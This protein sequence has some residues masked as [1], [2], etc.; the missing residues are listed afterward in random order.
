MS[1]RR[2]LPSVNRARLL[3][4]A[5]IG[6]AATAA[7]QERAS[8]PRIAPRS[9]QEALASFHPQHGFRLDLLAAEPLVTDPVALE[10]DENGR[11]YVAEMSDYP[12]TDKS[13]DRPF[14]E[15]STDRPLGRIRIL[16]DVDGDGRFDRSTIFAEQLSWPTGLAFWKGGVFVIATPDLWYLKDSDGDGRADVRRRV[17][18]GFR[19]FNIQAV[20]NNLRWG[21]DQRIYAAGSSNGGDLH[22]A[23]RPHDKTI[24]LG[25]ND[26]S[27]NP[28]DESIRIEAGGA[29]F[30]NSLDDWGN[31]FI[32]NIRNPIQ[33]VV[34]PNHYLARNPHLVVRSAVHDAANA[35]DTLPV[36][37]TSPPEPWRIVNADR[38]AGD[39]SQAAPRS[40]RVAAG[41]MTSACGIT[42]YRGDAYPRTFYGNAFLSDVAS[43]LI[44][45][46]TLVAN[47]ITFGANRADQNVEFVTSTDNWFRPV[48]FTNAPDGTLH[49]VDMYR[50][51]IEHPW[52][53]PDDIKSQLDLESGRDRGRIYRLTPPGFMRRPQPRLGNASTVQLVERLADPNGWCRDTA[54]R[55]LFERQDRTAVP[56]LRDRLR[57]ALVAGKPATPVAQPAPDFSAVARLHALTLLHA[58]G[59]LDD[60]DV[61][62]ALSDSATGVREFALRLAEPRLRQSP[63]LL[64]RVLEMTDDS[65]LRV[66]FQLAFTLGEVDD[67]AAIAALATVARRDADDEWLRAAVISSAART[68]ARLVEE[69]LRDSGIAATPG[70]RELLRNAARSVGARRD[71]TELRRLLAILQRLAESADSRDQPRESTEL[72]LGLADGM[73]R[74]Q[75]TL[76]SEIAKQAPGTEQIVERAVI[77][78][79]RIVADQTAPPDRRVQALEMLGLAPFPRAAP[80][81]AKLLDVRQPAPIQ[82][83]AVRTLASFRHADV[84]AVLIGICRGMSPAV[85]SEIVE[86]LFALPGG[87]TALL[88][89]ID[90][91][92]VRATDV[93]ASRRVMLLRHSD[94]QIKLQAQRIFVTA[95][96]QT[97]DGVLARYR[98]IVAAGGDRHRGRA[99]F[100]QECRGCHRLDGDGVDV[101]PNLESMRH[102]STTELLTHILDPNRDL[103]P[104][105]AEHVVALEDGRTLTGIVVDETATAVTL[106]RA[107]GAEQT[108][109]RTEIAELVNTGKSLMP[110]GLEERITPAALADLIQFVRES[111]VPPR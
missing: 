34:L 106:R 12:Y 36:F 16:D 5:W 67:A 41:Y 3:A 28:L 43:N 6:F 2:P 61:L 108:V 87:P 31:R 76:A 83:A 99:V 48:N 56:P 55:L 10:Y 60:D 27:L 88:N 96:Q 21:L 15:R 50:E 73:K 57:S 59:G 49:V 35:G 65:S 33:Q 29:R 23:S 95:V 14:T 37:R 74:S 80:T 7:N 64:D 92:Q 52:S 24:A 53:I 4:A 42:I 17:V 86:S 54:H 26:F 103:A 105:Y 63:R 47:G 110:E 62:L 44:Q 101:G 98:P 30:G 25:R 102:R 19:K 38:L 81:L 70:G 75:T 93:P 77:D 32:C 51:T 66:R 72:L 8:L 39:L 78:A 111:V 107:E 45:R 9:P 69:L 100:Q 46:Q 13:T 22:V 79:E 89:A 94:V 85:R 84:P 40:E 11:A 90:A 71:S 58:L 20:A 91:K 68:A 1:N 82:L 104:N 109:L 18:S 97:R